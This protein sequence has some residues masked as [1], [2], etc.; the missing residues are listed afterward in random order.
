M[1]ANKKGCKESGTFAAI[2]K[3]KTFKK[4]QKNI[5]KYFET[6]R[7]KDRQRLVNWRK[8]NALL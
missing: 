6:T 5:K 7:L 1:L 2:F 4:I 3:V 8:K